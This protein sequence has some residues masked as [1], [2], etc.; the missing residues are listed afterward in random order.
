MKSI[1]VELTDVEDMALQYAAISSQEWIQNAARYR[2]S[3]AIN[4]IVK[5]VIDK[6]LEEGVQI[7]GTKDDIVMLGFERKWVVVAAQRPPAPIISAS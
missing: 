7:P 4:E 6:C 2:S 3:E 1:N 5:I